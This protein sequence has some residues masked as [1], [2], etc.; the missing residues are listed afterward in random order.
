MLTVMQTMGPWLTSHTASEEHRA[1]NPQVIEHI[2]DPLQKPD[3]MASKELC[4]IAL[5]RIYVL[6]HG[7]ESLQRDIAT[8]TIPGFVTACL[9]VIKPWVSGKQGSTPLGTIELVLSSLATVVPLYHT[10]LRPFTSQI[11]LTIRPLLAPT[12]TDQL[13][14][15]S[16]LSSASQRLNSVL[17]YTVA[18][19]GDAAE[20]TKA[21]NSH[22]LSCHSAADQVFRPVQESWESSLGYLPRDIS[23]E[24]DPHGGSDSSEE[25]PVWSGMYSGSQ[26]LVGL[27]RLISEYFRCPTKSPVS[28]PLAGISDLCLRLSLVLPPSLDARR[29]GGFAMQTNPSVGREEREELWCLLPDIHIAV[30]DLYTSLIQRLGDSMKPLATEVL[31]Q[32]LRMFSANP[33]VSLMR[34]ASYPLF[35]GILILVGPALERSDVDKLTIIVQS[36][37]QDIVQI[38]G[39]AQEDNSP[40]VA[41]TNTIKSKTSS[42]HADSFLTSKKTDVQYSSAIYNVKLLEAAEALLVVFFSHLPRKHV[43]KADRALMD[44]TAIL[45]GSKRAMMASV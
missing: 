19:G 29:G 45:S 3:P 7:Y 10:T 12:A 39:F 25:L 8:P 11:R 5:T 31:D 18:K 17:H 42:T 20:W 44:R 6:L 35:A 43:N 9:Q 22:V 33:A 34:E 27:L 1:Q 41:N 40:T 26:R 14:V 16:F 23:F 2:A 13:V 38:K 15:P 37:C 36:C 28:I 24:E 21:M 30:I 32:T 4:L